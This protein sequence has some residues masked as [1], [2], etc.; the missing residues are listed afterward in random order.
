M[1]ALVGCG[2]HPATTDASG[3]DGGGGDDGS[4][5]N[6]FDAA[7]D[8]PDVKG[9]VHVQVT[10]AATALCSTG[11][12]IANLYVLF[13]DTDNSVTQAT[14]DA[15]G[16]AQGD[17]HPGGSVTAMCHRALGACAGVGANCSFTMV[18]VLDVEPGDNLVL[19]AN[20]FLTGRQTADVTS[21]GTF[22]DDEPDEAVEQTA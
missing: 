16:N 11:G 20:A 14:T 18:T 5:S 22:A 4:V 9:T 10:N 21:A 17:V 8:V 1:L 6:T 3:D 13:M 12:G 19:D 2:S 7:I 15:G